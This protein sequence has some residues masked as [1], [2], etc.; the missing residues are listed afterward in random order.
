MFRIGHGYDVHRLVPDRRLVLGGI[1]VGSDFGPD[2]H[3]DGDVL[4]HAVGSALL[5][6]LGLGDLGQHFPDTDE[7]F[8]GASSADLVRR[9]M[10]EVR[11][12]D[13]R[14]VNLDSTLLVER[15]RLASLRS[16]IVACI[17]DLLDASVEQVNVKFGRGEGVGPVGEANAIEA[18]AVVLLESV[19]N[20]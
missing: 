9:I 3:S 11:S 2:S 19:R 1:A 20:P 7:R 5:G 17:A 12:R 8:R 10:E 18:Y 13:F 6:A 15:P 14:V 16:A 4:L